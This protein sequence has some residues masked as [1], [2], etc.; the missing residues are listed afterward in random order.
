M[1][2][3]ALLGVTGTQIRL[4]EKGKSVPRQRTLL[5]VYRYFDWE[6]PV[7]YIPNKDCKLP[8]GIASCKMCGKEFPLYTSRVTCCSRE[9]KSLDL[10][11]R[12]K[13]L[14]F[15]EGSKSTKSGGYIQV[16]I[17]GGWVLEHRYTMEKS[18][19]RSLLPREL[20]HHK[21]GIRSDNRIENLELWTLEH[22]DPPG[23]RVSDMMIDYVYFPP[24][25]L[26]NP[27]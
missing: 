10:V 20:V 27:M 2:L 3:G 7:G 18:L 8:I 23:V 6:I 14:G 22:K 17:N 21:N 11:L 9:C 15:V 12:N 4:W 1:E 25:Y 13:S 5:E 24:E 16:K 19:G 26:V